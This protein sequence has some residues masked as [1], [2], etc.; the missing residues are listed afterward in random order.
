[1]TREEPKG[2]A[3]HD[4]SSDT[5]VSGPQPHAVGSFIEPDEEG[6]PLSVAIGL[7][8]VAAAALEWSLRLHAACL[9]YAKHAA[10]QQP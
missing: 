4:Q 7:A 1:M 6:A 5:P 9:L 8:V 2:P 10:P 3:G